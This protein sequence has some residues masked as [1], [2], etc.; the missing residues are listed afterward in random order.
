MNNRVFVIGDTHFGHKKIIDFEAA[1][2]PFASVEE[3]DA[4]LVRRWNATVNKHDTVWHLGD[5]LFGEASFAILP[6]LNGVKKL[7]M[8]NHDSY[9]AAKYL[10]HFSQICG[11]VQLRGYLLTHVPVHPGQFHRFKGNIHGHMHSAKIDDPRY[12]CVSAEH[13]GLAP[14]LL[15]AVIHEAAPV[16][17]LLFLKG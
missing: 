12:I 8:G 2:R 5:V 16:T 9:P 17:A 10:E 15:D 4:E 6:Q 13:T 11:A 1:A 14:K 3:H 7:V